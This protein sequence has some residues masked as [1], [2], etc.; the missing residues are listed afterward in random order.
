MVKCKYCGKEFERPH[1]H[2]TEE[3][4]FHVNGCELD[5]IEQRLNEGVGA[6]TREK[7]FN[8]LAYISKVASFGAREGNRYW[9]RMLRVRDIKK[10]LGGI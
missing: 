2:R 5:S 8:N 9:E 3:E 10:K 7:L 4:A 6:Y 1:R